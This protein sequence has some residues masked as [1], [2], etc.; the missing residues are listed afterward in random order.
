MLSGLVL[1]FDSAHGWPREKTLYLAKEGQMYFEDIIEIFLWIFT[2]P[3][4]FAIA[5]LAIASIKED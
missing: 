5:A 1:R 3:F 2:G 4:M